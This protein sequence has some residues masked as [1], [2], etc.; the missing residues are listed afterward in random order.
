LVARLKIMCNLDISERR[1]PQDGRIVFKQFT[2]KNMDLD[3]RV[4]TGPMKDGEK[5]VMRILDKQK[6]TLPLPALGFS[7]ENLAKY[8]ECIREPYGMLLHGGLTGTGKSMT[9]YSALGEVNTPDVNIQTAEEPTA[10]TLAGINQMQLTGQ[11]GRT[12]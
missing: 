4:A 10:Y 3:L 6:S 7:E 5:V 2:K 8:R 9:L 1:L 12:F 11:V